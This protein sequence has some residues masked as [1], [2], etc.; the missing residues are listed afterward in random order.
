M[1]ANI[2]Y[3]KATKLPPFHTP[4]G[5]MFLLVWKMRQSIEFQKSRSLIQ[6]LMSQQ[7]A[8]DESIK[9]VFDDLKESYFPYDKNQRAA[10]LKKMR[11]AMD[12]WVKHG[13]VVVEAQDDGRQK[14]KI[15]SRLL[16][17]QQNL[18]DRVNKEQQGKTTQLDPYTK[19]KRRSRGS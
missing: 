4:T 16:K 9:K 3:E 7:G 17:G 11:Q 18:K 10:E 8:Q 1:Q 5:I 12:Y 15:A 6:A 14:K 19:A 13:P 2:L